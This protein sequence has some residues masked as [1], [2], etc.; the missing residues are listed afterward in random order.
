VL[1]SGVAFVRQV[2]SPSDPA[3]L[4]DLR[5]WGGRHHVVRR[6]DEVS[7]RQALVEYLID[8]GTVDFPEAQEIVAQ[9]DLEIV[10]VV[11]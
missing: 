5:P 8:L 6:V 4:F 10:I 1:F 9:A 11:G 2:P 3:F 7:A